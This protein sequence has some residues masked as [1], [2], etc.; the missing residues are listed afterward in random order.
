M[1]NLPFSAIDHV[2]LAMPAGAEEQARAFYAGVLGMVE[3]PK[4]PQL[5]KRGGCWFASGE[6]Q[7]HVG[8]EADFRAARKAHPGLRCGDYEGLRARLRA[9]GVGIHDDDNIPGVRRCHIS[10]PFGNRIELVKA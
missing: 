5:A 4:P 9:A 2:Q 6:V 7:I 10:D 3:L 8:V 1:E